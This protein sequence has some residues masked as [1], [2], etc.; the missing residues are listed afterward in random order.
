MSFGLKNAPA[1]FWLM[2][3]VL[4]E[5]IGE[6]MLVYLDDVIIFAH[7]LEEYRTRFDHLA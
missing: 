4:G 3:N 5:L 1:T 7:S 6:E 2:D